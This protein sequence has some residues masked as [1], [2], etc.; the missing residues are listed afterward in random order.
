MVLQGESLA[1]Q[2]MALQMLTSGILAIVVYPIGKSEKGDFWHHLFSLV[3]MLNHFPLL[4][5]WN[6][7]MFYQMGFYV[8]F[9][10]FL[11]NMWQIRR[12]KQAYGIA[13]LS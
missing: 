5:R 3:Y 7:P 13:W 11:V 6:I 8:S 9:F 10:C 4:N 2:L 12:L 1:R